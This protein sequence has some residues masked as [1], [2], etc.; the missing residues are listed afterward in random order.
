MWC[1]VG[2]AEEIEINCPMSKIS[3]NISLP[4]V[5]K[6]KDKTIKLLVNTDEMKIYDNNEDLDLKIIH[7]IETNVSIKE[8]ISTSA[9]KISD[10]NSIN[11]D[12]DIELA[13]VEGIPNTLEGLLLDYKRKFFE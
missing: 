1:N 7:G 13:I 2:F 5:V 6:F 11:E 8:G 10:T 12:F 4:D 3:S 9:F